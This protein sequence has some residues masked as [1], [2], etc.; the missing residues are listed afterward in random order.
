[1]K[2]SKKTRNDILLFFS[3]LVIA[4][5]ILIAASIGKKEGSYAEIYIDGELYGVYSL[6]EE[7]TVDIGDT[8][9]A[10]IKDGC[11]YMVSAEC[12]DK[13]CMNRGRISKV[14]ESIVCLPNRVT[15]TI[16]NSKEKGNDVVIG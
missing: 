5:I 10:V 9:R 11:I 13:T 14:G 3:L 4:V 2:I 1:M 12:P 6:N 16:I 15:I 7:M 8:N